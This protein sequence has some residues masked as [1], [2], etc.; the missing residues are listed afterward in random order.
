MPRSSPTPDCVF[1]IP[2][3]DTVSGEIELVAHALPTRQHPLTSLLARRWICTTP[4]LPRRTMNPNANHPEPSYNLPS[5]PKPFRFNYTPGSS[6]STTMTST[7][8]RAPM[9]GGRQ[10]TRNRASYSCHTCRRRK[11]KCDKVLP[12]I[13]YLQS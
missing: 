6:G 7:I 2:S 10:I 12:T 5:L 8:R 1:A 4:R 9:A 3:C 11:V 13:V